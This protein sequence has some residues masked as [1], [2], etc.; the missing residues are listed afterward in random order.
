M[1]PFIFT[2]LALVLLAPAASQAQEEPSEPGTLVVSY[3]KCE[4][5]GIATL[6]QRYDSLS[7]HPE[8]PS[9]PSFLEICEEHRDGIYNYGPHTT[10]PGQ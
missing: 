2:A 1:R 8:P 9:D 5:D 7:K 6:V 4:W 3:W 10:P